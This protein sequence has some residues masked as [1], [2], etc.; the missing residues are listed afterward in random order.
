M[1][2]L[3]LMA[4]PA[5]AQSVTKVSLADPTVV[6]GMST[7]GTVTLSAAAPTGGYKVTM[8][9]GPYGSG[10]ATLTVAANQTTGTFTL[11]A[12]TASSNRSQTVMAQGP[13]LVSASTTCVII[14][15]TV[16]KL[17]L[18]A[19]FVMAGQSAT[20]T[21]SLNGK[22]AR[23]GLIVNLTSSDPNFKVPTTVTVPYLTISVTFPVNAAGGMNSIKS[24]VITATY[25]K[26]KVTGTLTAIPSSFPAGFD[27][28]FYFA[29]FTNWWLEFSNE[30]GDRYSATAMYAEVTSDGTLTIFPLKANLTHV[31]GTNPGTSVYTSNGEKAYLAYG[32]MSAEG[33]V[34]LTPS[35]NLSDITHGISQSGTHNKSADWGSDRVKVTFSAGAITLDFYHQSVIASFNSPADGSYHGM[36][37]KVGEE[38]L[39]GTI[40]LSKIIK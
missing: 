17:E 7:T 21:L 28:G 15:P 16:T 1:I 10:P 5:L 37:F 20:A 11:S 29:E 39:T 34:R 38:Q 19:P 30:R 6:S 23:G 36:V 31:G 35:P 25:G 32:K 9:Y 2:F 18:S 33:Y 14:P 13:D 8:L 40:T 22:P 4:V 12:Q 27:P 24:T 26:D 3:C